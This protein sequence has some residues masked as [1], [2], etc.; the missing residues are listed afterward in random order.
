MRKTLKYAIALSMMVPSGYGQSLFDQASFKSMSLG[1]IHLYG[2]SVYSGYSTS[3]YPGTFGQVSSLAASQF[4]PGVDYGAS[5]TAGWQHHQGRADFSAAYSLTYGGRV[6]YPEAS[7]F[8]QS[9]SLSMSRVLTPKWM[10]GLSMGGSYSTVVQLLN[11]PSSVGLIAQVPATLD[12]LA[13]SFSIGQFSNSQVASMLTSAPMLESPARVMLL[14]GRVLAYSVQ[15]SLQYARSSR[16]S[17]HIS[18]FTA[19]GE[20]YTGGD[21][22]PSNQNYVMP[23]SIG[24]SGGMGMS[25]MLSPRTQVGVNLEENRV[26]NAYQGAY[27]TSAGASIGRKMSMRWFV[28]AHGGGS[29]T[30]VTNQSY[31]MPQTRQA[32]WGGSI[33]FRTYQHTLIGSYDRSAM[34][35]FG[36]AIGTTTAASAGWSWHRPGSRWSVFSGFGQQQ[37]KNTGYSSLSGWQASGGVSEMLSGQASLSV[38]YAYGSSSGVFLGRAIT[39]DVHSVRLSLGWAPS[40]VIR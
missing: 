34:D 28:A 24:V 20:H 27:V 17:F 8:N 26:L 32:T 11:Q 29:F 10:L 2:V 7:A 25:Y 33:G 36:F 21:N 15:A 22:G 6:H 3:G 13:A 1:G 14:G 40:P 37:V 18:S 9:L 23:H 39:T 38:Q 5:A 12:D 19:G 16:L 4:G 31:G 35:T 30:R